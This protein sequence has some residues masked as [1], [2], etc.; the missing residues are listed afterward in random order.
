MRDTYNEEVDELCKN[1]SRIC[2]VC[3]D[4]DIF[5]RAEDTV[6]LEPLPAT[7]NGDEMKRP[8]GFPRRF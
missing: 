8:G 2:F 3:H 7:S 5:I 4:P 1:V 6:L